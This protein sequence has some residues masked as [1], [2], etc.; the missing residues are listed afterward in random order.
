MD[1]DSNV[2]A[3]AKRTWT[4]RIDW[5]RIRLA[6]AWPMIIALAVGGAALWVGSISS[7]LTTGGFDGLASWQTLGIIMLTYQAYNTYVRVTEQRGDFQSVELRNMQRRLQVLL[8]VTVANMLFNVVTIVLIVAS[9]S[10]DRLAWTTPDTIGYAAVIVTLFAMLAI[11]RGQVF[12]SAASVFFLVLSTR[13]IP[14][15]ALVFSADLGRIPMLALGGMTLISLFRFAVSSIELVEARVRTVSAK[16]R[17]SA[18]WI[19]LADV[20]NL[21]AIAVPVIAKISL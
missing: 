20:G 16:S 5:G 18:G 6:F 11:R 13:I 19:W 2:D 7:L 4:V 9:L 14:Q 3:I 12:S 1:G 10:A 8:V 21:V 15:G 17:A